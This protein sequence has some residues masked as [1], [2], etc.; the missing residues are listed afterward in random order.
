MGTKIINLSQLCNYIKI[1][2]IN[3]T[4]FLCAL[5]VTI[6]FG[7]SH[8]LFLVAFGFS[9]SGC[10]GFLLACPLLSYFIGVSSQ[11]PKV[12]DGHW[13]QSILFIPIIVL[14]SQSLSR[15]YLRIEQERSLLIMN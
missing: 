11:L 7:L 4:S 1:F 10:I 14:T 15:N 2:V 5:Y 3:G 12:L 13:F 9:L 6:E 8:L